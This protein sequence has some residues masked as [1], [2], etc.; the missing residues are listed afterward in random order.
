[1]EKSTGTSKKH[2]VKFMENEEQFQ[3]LMDSITDIVV[4]LDSDLNLL[5]FNKAGNALLPKGYKKED[6]IGK[7]VSLISHD[8][9]ESGRYEKYLKVLETGEPYIENDFIVHLDFGKMNFSSTTIKVGEHLGMILTDISKTKESEEIIKEH[10]QYQTLIDGISRSIINSADISNLFASITKHLKEILDFD[11]ASLLQV[12]DDFESGT[13]L[14]LNPEQSPRELKRGERIK[15][16]DE[17]LRSVSSKEGVIRRDLTGSDEPVDIAL[18]EMGINSCINSP[19]ISRDRV[20]GLFNIGSRNVDA[21]T[22]KDMKTVQSISDLIAPAIERAFIWEVLE[23]SEKSFRD[24]AER[25]FDIICKLDTNGM[26]TYIS[27]AITRAT[28][29]KPEQLM[30]KPIRKFLYE[31]E[32]P[33][34]DQANKILL[35][36]RN[37]EGLELKMLSK[38][39]SMI[40]Y[41]V[42][43]NPIYRG[44]RITGVQGIARD[45]SDRKRA[46]EEMRKRLMKFRLE[47]G[48]LYLVQELS[49]A[50][51]LEAFMDML[52]IGYEGLIISRTPIKDLKKL[53]SGD[54]EFIWLS[55]KKGENTLSPMLQ[56]IEQKIEGGKHR[57]IVYLDRLDY[58]ISKHGFKNVLLF[59]QRLK[60]IAI[61]TNKVIIIS[62]DP[63]ILS[64][65][66]LRLLEKEAVEVEPLYKPKL[67]EHLIDVLKYIYN[68]NIMG[69]KPSYTAI[70]SEL[71]M[72]KPTVR[73]RIRVLIAAGYIKE[74]MRG[75]NK[76]LEMTDRGK[77]LFLR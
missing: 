67:P 28:G 8:S 14:S 34:L 42:N 10:S 74:N 53:V 52:N 32:I 3:S 33:K 37:I 43:V 75:R 50:L 40:H 69:T 20:I 26:I 18:V 72:S 56:R 1:M 77:D 62:I 38:N 64:Q 22:E 35:K 49:P 47:E 44:T 63:S 16:P 46:E 13:I 27:P 19:L 70:G 9:Q 15:I 65:T 17:T 51:S 71:H 66:E 45:I 31:S 4:I 24:I 30:G 25:S 68:Q 76:I 57:K 5:D 6:L 54:I 73:K 21:Y 2:L 61:I 29:Y 48:G 55:E 7:N 60:E 11:R 59:I 23:E 36:G 41:E 58:L 12:H 39:G